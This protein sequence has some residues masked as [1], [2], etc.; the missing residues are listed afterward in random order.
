LSE[1]IARS[2]T[3]LKPTKRQAEQTHKT[4]DKKKWRFLFRSKSRPRS[5]GRNQYQHVSRTPTGVLARSLAPHTLVHEGDVLFELIVATS[6]S[7]SELDALKELELTIEPIQPKKKLNRQ[8]PTSQTTSTSVRVDLVRLDQLMLLVGELIVTRARL[9]KNLKSIRTSIIPA[10][11]RQLK[12]SQCSVWQN[13]FE[14]CANDV[15]RVRMVADS[16]GV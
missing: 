3:S 15:M 6:A 14:I 12:E 5:E 7:E 9:E 11:W 2:D 1:V 16:G 4:Q 10:Q 8:T 13:N